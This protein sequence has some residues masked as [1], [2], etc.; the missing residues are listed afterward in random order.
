M[1]VP[2]GVLAGVSADVSAHGSEAELVDAA[3]EYAAVYCCRSVEPAAAVAAAEPA[4]RA[5]AG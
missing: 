1:G 5:V 3:A 2:A 4:A